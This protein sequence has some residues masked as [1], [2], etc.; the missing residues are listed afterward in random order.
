[1]AGVTL[2]S[3]RAI[4]LVAAVL[5]HPL[6]VTAAQGADPRPDASRNSP[7]GKA[8]DTV[9]LAMRYESGLSVPRDY[10]RALTLYCEAAR[11][12]DARA[13]YGLG[14]MYLN[15]RGVARDEA[16]AVM[17]LRKAADRGIAQAANLLQLLSRVSPAPA[18]DCPRPLEGSRQATAKAFPRASAPPAIRR[19][20]NETAQH[21]GI[22]ARL[23]HSV[24][25]V[26][27][28][29]DPRAVSPKMAAGLMQLMPATAERFGVRDRFDPRENIRAGAT[30]LRA[31]IDKYKGDLA[32]ALAAYNAGEAKVD[33]HGGV[34]PYEETQAYI[35]AVK[36][37]CR[38]GQDDR[39]KRGGQSPLA[40]AAPSDHASDGER[41]Q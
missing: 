21:I 29:F 22:D 8:G 41:D 28:G 15:G 11:R 16:T 13:Y 40:G 36:R 14:W 32:L 12:G 34:P 27:S 33:A 10:G 18:R 20:I 39:T 26:E 24:V 7:A 2:R 5:S 23:L 30:Y 19:L 4:L 31:L 1:M 25:L 17:W 9:A 35:A 3:G 6:L 38:C 37:L